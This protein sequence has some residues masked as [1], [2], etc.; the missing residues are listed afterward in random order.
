MPSDSEDEHLASAKITANR[1]VEILQEQDD[2]S[3]VSQKAPLDRT[4]DIVPDSQL[5]MLKEKPLLPGLL[6]ITQKNKKSLSKKKCWVSDSPASSCSTLER[7]TSCMKY[8]FQQDERIIKHQTFCSI[9]DEK[10]PGQGQCNKT[11]TL[12]QQQPDKAAKLTPAENQTKTAT[13]INDSM[14]RINHTFDRRLLPSSS[15]NDFSK[16]QGLSLDSTEK[17][18]SICSIRKLGVS[19][20]K[21][22]EVCHNTGSKEQNNPQRGDCSKRHNMDL[23]C[24]SR[25]SDERKYSIRKESTITETM[26]SAIAAK[27]TNEKKKTLN[28]GLDLLNRSECDESQFL[29]K[30]QRKKL[31]EEKGTPK[32]HK[33]GSTNKSLNR[34][35]EDST[36]DVYRFVGSSD[37]PTI[38]LGMKYEPVL[39]QY[40]ANKR[41]TVKKKMKNGLTEKVEHKASRCRKKKYFFTDTDTDGKTDVSWLRESNRK[42]KPKLVAYTRQKK[43]NLAESSGKGKV[44]TLQ[45]KHYEKR[46]KSTKRIEATNSVKVQDGRK[47]RTCPRRSTAARP[48]YKEVSASEFDNSE[49]SLSFSPQSERNLTTGTDAS[50]RIEVEAKE[51]GLGIFEKGKHHGSTSSG[52]STWIIY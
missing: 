4:D 27:Y 18:S 38:T 20:R 19:G 29:G 25:L 12:E 9:F 30:M 52:Y 41:E 11:Q 50:R 28:K 46:S 7:Q 1:V 32:E 45:R 14:K 43:Q 49:E 17:M 33:G 48:C 6:E 13:H 23:T 10:S 5:V 44:A 16:T 24:K 34:K 40:C 3:S 47:K 35:I 39:Q 51:K 21:F 42:I 22:D 37:E 8:T 31:K 26:I 15:K 36:T 2:E